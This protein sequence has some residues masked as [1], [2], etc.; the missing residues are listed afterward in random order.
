MAI[1]ES[2]VIEHKKEQSFDPESSFASLFYF[3]GSCVHCQT[4]VVIF[5]PESKLYVLVNVVP[6]LIG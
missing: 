2:K 3:E 4:P 6:G 5:D 1:D